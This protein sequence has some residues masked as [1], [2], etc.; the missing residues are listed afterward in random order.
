MEKKTQTKNFPWIVQG[1]KQWNRLDQSIL[2]MIQASR[3]KELKLLQNYQIALQCLYTKGIV[4]K[5][6]QKT[7][8]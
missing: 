1:R 3:Q 2:H 7:E 5:L 4:E 6:H 8:V